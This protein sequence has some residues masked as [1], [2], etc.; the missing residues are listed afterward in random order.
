[1]AFDCVV[2][3]SDKDGH[4]YH[5]VKE[6][7]QFMKDKHKNERFTFSIEG[8]NI[9]DFLGECGHQKVHHLNQDQ[10]ET[11]YQK[12]ADGSSTGKQNGLF[13]MLITSSEV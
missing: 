4:K 13:N 5:G 2:S 3:F 11:T 1:L 10:I 7:L 8:K 9:A 6:M 12:K